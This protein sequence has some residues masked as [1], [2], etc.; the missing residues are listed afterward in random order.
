M[1]FPDPKITDYLMSLTPARSAV[2][3]EME[4]Y[5][6]EHRFP[7]IGPLVGRLLYQYARLVRPRRIM[8]LG[9]G[10][11]YSAMWW[12]L[13]TDDDCEIHCTEG[14]AENIRRAEDF[15][16]RAGVLHKVTYHEG[17]ALTSF[18]KIPGEF[19]IILMDIDKH[20]YPAAFRQAFPRL[21][22]GGVFITDNVLWSGRVVQDS[23]PDAD[24]QGILEFNHLAH[25]T[26]GALTT[27]IPLRDGVAVTVKI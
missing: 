13:A 9:S 10:F 20:E 16:R 6:R 2:L 15:L 19:D 18:A 23:P 11:G 25:T 21:R 24:T 8:E 1:Q 14:S 26:P 12:A 7:A 3:Q 4:D 22:S 5:A 17:D 27:I